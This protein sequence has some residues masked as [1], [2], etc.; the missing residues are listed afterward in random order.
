MKSSKDDKDMAK[1]SSKKSFPLKF[2]TET[3]KEH[4]AQTHPHLELIS[5]YGK[6]NDDFITVRCRKHGT[7]IRTTP[8]RL[9]ANKFCCRQCYIEDKSKRIRERHAAK[10]I[11][12]LEEHYSGIYDIS[13]VEYVNNRTKVKLVC[14]I[15]GE[16]YLTPNK[17]MSRLD[18]CPYC[19]ESKLEKEVDRK[20]KHEGVTFERQRTF[21]WLI[22]KANMFLDFYIPERNLAIECQ[23][24]QHYDERHGTLLAPTEEDFYALVKRDKLKK[25]LCEEHGI[26]LIYVVADKP[27]NEEKIVNYL[28]DAVKISGL[29][30]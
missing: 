19:H 23:G 18:G 26:K 27:K 2:T 12:F 6:D 4:L 30:V 10:F 11:Q 14:P 22:D 9:N 17:I 3:F 21:P 25:K 16:F 8:H 15:H 24:E 13:E 1:G 20:L 5:E 7:V 29:V 28:G